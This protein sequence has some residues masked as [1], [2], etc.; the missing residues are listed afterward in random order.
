MLE[1]F[2]PTELVGDGGGMLFD[3]VS[4]AFDGILWGVIVEE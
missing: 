2:E 3:G 1:K 4:D